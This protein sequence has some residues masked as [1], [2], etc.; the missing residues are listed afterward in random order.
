MGSDHQIVVLQN[1]IMDGRDRQVQ[2]QWLP[3]RTS[4]VG[5]EHSG[6]GACVK[7]ARFHGVFP[8][9]VHIGAIRDT[10]GDLQPGFSEIAGLINIWFEIVE[11]VAIDGRESRCGVMRRG[12]DQADQAPLRHSFGRNV[13]P[14]LAS[15][16]RE[17]NESVICTH[18]E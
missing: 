18:P 11:L 12:L 10:F 15:V 2:L 5:N 17:L 3:I 16:L 7:N 14:T 4:V 9:D 6:F 13:L 8:D 1:K